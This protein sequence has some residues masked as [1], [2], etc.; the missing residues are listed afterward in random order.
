MDEYGGE[1]REDG[2]AE[3]VWEKESCGSAGSPAWRPR[4]MM[5]G[6][7][8]GGVG[9]PECEQVRWD[10]LSVPIFLREQD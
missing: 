3:L 4:A 10:H 7:G 2:G 9:V 5:L 8:G 1:D 6:C